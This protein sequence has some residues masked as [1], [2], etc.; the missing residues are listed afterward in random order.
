MSTPA[1]VVILPQ[2]M[3][4]TVAKV[5]RLAKFLRARRQ[6]GSPQRTPWENLS[7]SDQDWWFREALEH[8]AAADIVLEREQEVPLTLSVGEAAGLIPPQDGAVH[9]LCQT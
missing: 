2:R 7:T 5:R 1:P 6:G 3:V 4:V 8:L 9:Q